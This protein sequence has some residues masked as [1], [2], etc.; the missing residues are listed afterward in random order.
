[1]YGS[2]DGQGMAPATAPCSPDD[3]SATMFQQLGIGPRHQ[4]KTISGR[5]VAIF[6]EGKVIQPLVG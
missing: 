2:T 1:V 6:R 4:V 5:P 3:V